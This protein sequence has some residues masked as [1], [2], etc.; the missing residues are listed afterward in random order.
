M[1]E[2]LTRFIRAGHAA[3][4]GHSK[5]RGIG[6]LFL[7]GVCRSVPILE[8]R[9]RVRR[10]PA[11]DQNGTIPE[12][13]VRPDAEILELRDA[14]DSGLSELSDRDRAILRALYLEGK[15]KDDICR[16]WEYEQM[17]EF[18][19]VLSALRNDFAGPGTAN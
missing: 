19:V 13:G 11:S 17:L 18:R 8:Y 14:I 5:Y 15:E 9:R 2:T 12:K 6:V 16:E 10:D 3:S 7:N 1:Q 4:A